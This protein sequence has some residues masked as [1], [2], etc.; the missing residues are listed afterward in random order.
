MLQ[1]LLAV[2]AHPDDETF[3]PGGTLALLAQSGVSVD[4]LTFTRGEAGSCGSPPLCTP[5]ELPIVRERE[6]HCACQVLGVHPPRLLDYADG[7][8]QQVSQEQMIKR[9]VSTIQEVKPQILLSFGPDG[10][11]KH[12][13][14]IAVG[15]FAAEGFRRVD[16]VLA[17]YTLAVP[18][19]L[20]ENLN[21][22]QVCPVPDE[23]I[24]LTVDISSVWAKKM[25]ALRCHATQWS[26]SPIASA[27]E[28]RR[29]LFLGREYFVRMLSRCP[30]RD[31]LPHVLREF[32]V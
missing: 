23:A 15:R 6:L 2:F 11:S 10:L 20:A 1:S 8:L 28:E 30:D 9:V 22:P 17:L 19:S 3:R 27:S 14:H 32:I 4:V 26:S 16:E 18:R 5:D 21:M 7:Q 31:Y 25:A 12:P 13:D 24:T 29:Q